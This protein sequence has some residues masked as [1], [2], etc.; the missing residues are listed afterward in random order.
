MPGSCGFVVYRLYLL[1]F[2][3]AA[4]KGVHFSKV[5]EVGTVGSTC[6]DVGQVRSEKMLEEHWSYPLAERFPG[7][8][9][10]MVTMESVKGC[11]KA[12]VQVGPLYTQGVH[13]P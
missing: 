1:V 10:F 2:V 7:F 4:M 6:G 8:I 3:G 11:T 12:L 13:E 5:L 9:C